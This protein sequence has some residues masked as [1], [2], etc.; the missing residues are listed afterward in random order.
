MHLNVYAGVCSFVHDMLML[1]Y[2]GGML[3]HTFTTY[4]MQTVRGRYL[5]GMIC[6]W[7]A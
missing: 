7:Y 6:L 3:V 1:Q 5:T 4:R 2:D